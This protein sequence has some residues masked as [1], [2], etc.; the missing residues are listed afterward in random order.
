[1]IQDPIKAAN[2]DDLNKEI[3]KILQTSP[4]DKM[5][6]NLLSGNAE[7][8]DY[9]EKL[10]QDAFLSNETTPS[11]TSSL[12]TTSNTHQLKVLEV[13][14]DPISTGTPHKLEGNQASVNSGASTEASTKKR[15]RNSSSASIETPN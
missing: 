6:R 5:R 12:A 4:L 11:N 10:L 8:Y 2:Y 3:A 9:L 7:N 14:E 13:A 15:V 1:M